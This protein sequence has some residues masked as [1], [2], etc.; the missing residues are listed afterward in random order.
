MD[1]KV[2]IL[3]KLSPINNDRIFVRT[4]ADLPDMIYV[5]YRNIQKIVNEG[6]GDVY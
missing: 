6:Y 2:S 4:Q 3:Y 1:G 5:A